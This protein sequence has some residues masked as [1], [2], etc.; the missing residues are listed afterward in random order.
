M[1]AISNAISGAQC[2]VQAVGY[3]KDA[4]SSAGRSTAGN[5]A[6]DTSATNAPPHALTA[7]SHGASTASPSA[8]V[9]TPAAAML[10]P[11][12]HQ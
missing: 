1:T 12:V 8:S 11:I 9:S 10:H 6:N 2:A 4:K 5:I 7:A 3:A